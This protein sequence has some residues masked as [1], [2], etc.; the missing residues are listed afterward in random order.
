VRTV[1]RWAALWGFDP[2]IHRIARRMTVGGCDD[3]PPQSLSERRC[4][5]AQPECGFNRR[6]RA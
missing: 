5:T 6:R 1:P 2:A 4:R 3:L